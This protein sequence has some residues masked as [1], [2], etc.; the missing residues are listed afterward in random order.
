MTQTEEVAVAKSE[1]LP[2][3][4]P[5][6]L[7][8]GTFWH[9]EPTEAFLTE[10]D[11][12]PRTSYAA[13][14]VYI[15]AKREEIDPQVL[16]V[17]ANPNDTEKFAQLKGGMRTR[18]DAWKT[19]IGRFHPFRYLDE[20]GNGLLDQH[21]LDAALEEGWEESGIDFAEMAE[22]FLSSLKRAPVAEYR[23]KSDRPGS[24][25]H[26]DRVHFWVTPYLFQPKKEIWG[27]QKELTCTR[28]FPL[29]ELPRKYENGAEDEK[30]ERHGAGASMLYSHTRR[31]VEFL[32]HPRSASI[33]WQAGIPDDAGARIRNRFPEFK[34]PQFS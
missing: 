1:P 23:K 15:Y 25:F 33:R 18:E 20:K 26:I 5:F 34:I 19:I 24:D 29:F 21:L 9:W 17:R 16:V 13:N 2:T 4:E 3:E 10:K 14:L 7:Q 8:L 11:L 28:Y 27:K 6:R 31:I 30:G 32:E 22:E 12:F